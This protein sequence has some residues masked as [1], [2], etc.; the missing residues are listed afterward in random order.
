MS[1][2][3]I[4]P[5]SI[6]GG[7]EQSRPVPEPTDLEELQ[8]FAIYRNRL[9]LRAPLATV[10]TILNNAGTPAAVDS[11]IDI[12]EHDGKM[13]IL[14]YDD[15]LNQIGLHSMQVD[16]SSLTY[17]ANVYTSVSTK[18]DLMMV[19][20]TAGDATSSQ[21]RLYICDYN[22]NLA[23]VYWNG[24]SIVALTQDFDANSSAEAV[25]FSLMTTFNFSL[26]GTGFFEGST[27]RPEMIRVSQPG[28]IPF[29]DPA[30]GTNPR[31]FHST[32]HE[33][34]GRRGDKIVALSQ[35]GDRLIVFQKRATHSLYG[36]G[37]D[38]YTTQQVSNVIGAVGPRAVTSVDERVCYFWAS[39]GP[40]R[41]DGVSLQYIGDPIRQ[42][43]VEVDASEA[44]TR[45][46]YSPDDGLVYFIV[47][48]G[49]ANK[50][51]LALIFD[52]RNERWMKTQ[53][54]V[55]S[56]DPAEFG[57][58]AFMD[59]IS[60]PAPAAP[61]SSFAATATGQST[62]DLSWTNTDTNV[63]T[64]TRI[65]RGS[66]GFTPN[67]ASNGI[68]ELA[69]GVTTYTDT[70]RS[71]ITTY[72]YK[73]KHRK[74][75]Q[76]STSSTAQVNAKTWLAAPTAALAGLTDGLTVSGT[77]NA[78][79][80]DVVI[81]TSTN[82]TSWST[83]TTLSNPGGTYSHAHTGLT[84]GNVYYYRAKSTKS[85][86]TT[87]AY[88][89]IVSR[90]AGLASAAPAAPTG[91]SI[92]A[93]SPTT[94]SLVL[95]WTDASTNEDSF[96]IE[97]SADDTSDYQPIQA[98]Y[99]P[100]STSF[101]DTG[102]DSNRTYHYKLRSE[103][104]AGASA[105]V[106][107][108]RATVPDLDPPEPIEATSPTT[109]TIT[110][111]WTNNASDA[112]AIEVHQSESSGSGYTKVAELSSDTT[113][114]TIT[115]LQPGT[116]FY[117]KLR[118]KVGSTVGTSY[119]AVVTQTTSGS[120]PSAP[121]WTSTYPKQNS[122]TPTSVIDLSYTEV[123]GETSY[124]IQRKVASASDW[125]PLD[126]IDITRTSDSHDTV[127]TDTGLASGETFKYRVRAVNS[128]GPSAWTES[129]NVSTSG[130]TANPADPTSFTATPDGSD[131]DGTEMSAVALAW[132]DN[133]TNE[134]GYEIER[135]TGA[136]CSSFSSLVS[137]AAGSTSFRDDTVTDNATA[138]TKYRYRVRAVNASDES[139]WVTTS[140]ID[141]EPQ[142]TPSSVTVSDTSA[143]VSDVAV[144]KVRVSWSDG[145]TTGL[146]D[147]V[148]LRSQDGVNYSEVTDNPTST[149]YHDDTTVS[150]GN[151]Y[152]Y[153]VTYKFGTTG[154]N[155]GD[156]TSSASS[157][158]TP[159]DPNCDPLA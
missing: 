13:Y 159:V 118:A 26:W 110:L 29:T 27:L 36:S 19:S 9:G 132:T 78:S 124:E 8:N 156:F 101:T 84:V 146:V 130:S 120:A 95:S 119:S 150:F 97:R 7:I 135:C 131:T 123:T 14:S 11:I 6:P 41:T 37:V 34:F 67:Y 152:T 66:D 81:E 98:T 54:L 105:Y 62:I 107:A 136:S 115:G 90:V 122:S 64:V 106:T 80:S 86:E 58:L 5:I 65:Y 12:T 109:S 126:E 137:L 43:A 49:G 56:S 70:G 155:T 142:A 112:T 134:T 22:Q 108:N 73:A 102:L 53:W 103:N 117:F 139:N 113:T 18:P 52:H 32:H 151:S 114:T 1:D 157:S 87:S 143:C 141:V 23:T 93:G 140:D 57:A 30:G 88:S 42:L 63:N 153:K 35:A 16:G 83:L 33:S 46:G 158:I 75:S 38:S 20:I 74:N 15:D 44:D 76:D 133:A 121:S 129:S 21:D 100:N 91:F 47:S 68:A 51:D 99:A 45:V 79:G 149:S 61:P 60:A 59:S 111:T 31:E 28:L 85:G 69:S 145:D 3:Q 77:N 144:P 94:T 39:D 72:Y 116:A 10:A 48:E 50:Y 138:V 147:R 4:F 128:T 55:G 25:K 24:S 82:G 2:L 71:P 17:H 127:F 89:D 96:R 148:I 154:E 40:Y 125:P 104:T 92:A